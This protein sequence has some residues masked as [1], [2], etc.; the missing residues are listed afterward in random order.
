AAPKGKRGRPAQPKAEAPVV[1]ETVAAPKGKRGRPA[2]PKAEAPEALPEI[3]PI[4]PLVT[5]AAY[6]EASATE[7]DAAYDQVHLERMEDKIAKL[8]RQILK[9]QKKL[10]KMKKRVKYAGK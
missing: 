4:E 7:Q 1:T 2:Q 9:I 8:E 5:E 3:K 10:L 6:A